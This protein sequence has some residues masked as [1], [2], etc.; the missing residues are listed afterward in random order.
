VAEEGRRSA[1]AQQLLKLTSPGISDVYQGDELE[2]LNLVDPDNRRPVDW[3]KSARA[4]DD[5]PP[6]LALILQAAALRSRLGADYEPLD[7]GP[8]VVAF[9]RGEVEVAVPVR[10]SADR[11]TMLVPSWQ[12]ARKQ[13]SSP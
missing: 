13:S 8:D 4:L 10:E 5:P 2:A 6:K 9:R 1:L 3:A 12:P 7:R 11:P